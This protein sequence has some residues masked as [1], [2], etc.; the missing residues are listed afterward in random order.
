MDRDQEFLQGFLK[1]IELIYEELTVMHH[2]PEKFDRRVIDQVWDRVKQQEI[3][4]RNGLF[5]H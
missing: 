5:S 3:R 4:A 2:S 1:A